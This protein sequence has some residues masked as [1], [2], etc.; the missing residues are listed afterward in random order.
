MNQFKLTPA[1]RRTKLVSLV[2]L[3]VMVMGS[4]GLDQATKVHAQE[5]LMIWQDEQDPSHY[6][7]R[8]HPLWAVGS[9]FPEQGPLYL[10]LSVNYVRNL[11]A[12]WGVLSGLDDSIR[13]PFFYG[14]TLVAVVIIGLYL[15]STPVHHRLAIFALA[16]ILSGAIGN[17]IDRVRLGFVIDWIDVR[18]N[19]FGW[20][21]EFPNFNFADSA[22]T[23]GVCMLMFDMLVLD[24]ARRKREAVEV[25][26]NA[27]KVSA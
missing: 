21:Y 7:G 22:I 2:Y 18:W 3:I 16:L 6:Q 25:V 15:R 8:R 10:A 12:A 17:F 14:V 5:S 27:A 11:G 13:V 26:P 9:P 19:L 24:A 20:K 23:V 4:I 1:A